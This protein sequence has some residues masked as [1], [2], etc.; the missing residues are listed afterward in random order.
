VERLVA[1]CCSIDAFEFNA[2]RASAISASALAAM[3]ACGGRPPIVGRGC[4]R[5]K[6][7]HSILLPCS[8]EMCPRASL[9]NARKRREI[10][11]TPGSLDPRVRRK[12]RKK[13]KRR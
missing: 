5:E 6:S 7:F 3:P 8:P 11:A 4:G 12:N 13:Q 2:V 1:T 9:G 10:L